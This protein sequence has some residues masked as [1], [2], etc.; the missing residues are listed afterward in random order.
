MASVSYSTADTALRE[1]ADAVTQAVGRVTQAKGAISAEKVR[2]DGLPTK[3]A[4][5]VTW[6]NDNAATHPD[7]KNRLDALAS[8]FQARSTNVTAMETALADLDV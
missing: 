2:L 4:D 8:D 5:V 3:Y 6:I 7:L 1:I